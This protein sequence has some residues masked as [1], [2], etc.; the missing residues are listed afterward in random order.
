VKNYI[1]LKPEPQ[2]NNLHKF[3]H[4]NSRNMKIILLTS[5]LLCLSAT[6]PAQE[7]TMDGDFKEEFSRAEG[8][9]NKDDLTDIAIV[10]RSISNNIEHYR[11]QVFFL[12][13]DGKYQL[14]TTTDKAIAPKLLDT[15][16]G[17]SFTGV[18]IKK[19]VLTLNND[20]LRG[21]YKHKF[22]FQGNE[23]ELIGYSITSFDNPETGST[24]DFN[25]STGVRLKKVI[26]YDDSNGKSTTKNTKETI[27]IKPLPALRNFEPNTSNLY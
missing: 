18:E 15:D 14:A 23:F 19:G 2:N 27:H 16:N 25:L 12:K 3:K 9:L 20:L 7:K 1:S 24:I 13:P 21:N 26:S 4:I 11:L 5:A 22:R 17:E 8:D 10:L 6:A